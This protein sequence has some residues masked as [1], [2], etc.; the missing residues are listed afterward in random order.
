MVLDIVLLS[1][2]CGT[3][4]CTG[5]RNLSDG[6]VVHCLVIMKRGILSVVFYIQH[7]RIEV[8]IWSM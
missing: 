5:R 7:L 1:V 8:R 3:P 2:D 6:K 4:R